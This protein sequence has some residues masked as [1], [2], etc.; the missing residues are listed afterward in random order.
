MIGK[1]VSHY[2]ITRELGAGGM[3]VVY[4]A[5]DTK[6]DRTVALKFLPPESTRDPDAKARFVHEAKAASAIDHPNVCNIYEIDETD[7]GQLFLA[8][9]C[10]EGE[11][12]KKRIE[13]GPLPLDDALDITRQVAE[14]LAKAHE[15]DI[16]HRDIKPANIFITEDGVVKIL[17]FGLAK[18]AGQAL[19]TKTGT[20][21]GTAGYMSPEQGRGEATDHRTDL[22]CLGVVLYE[23][24]TG[25]RPFLGDHEQALIYSILNQD[26]EPVTGLRTGVSMELER[27]ID[28]CLE[29]E[30]AARY[31]TAGD[32]ASDLSRHQ[33]G[34]DSAILTTKTMPLKIQ[35][36][37]R[38]PLVVG[39]GVLT[40]VLVLGALLFALNVGNLRDRWHGEENLSPIRSL[41]VLPFHNLMGDAE[42][43]FFVEGMH[44]SLITE[45]S[46]IGTLRVISRTSAMYFRETDKSMPEIAHELDVDALVE[47][48]VLR[49][50]NRVR[51][52]AQLIRGSND[53][54]LWA[55]DYDRDL[56]DILNLLSEVAR[57]I[58]GEID[59]ALTPGQQERLTTER[60]VDPDVYEMFLR[61][62]H[63][64]HKFTE[65]DVLISRDYFQQ[66]I[67]ADPNFALAHAGLSGSLI[68]SSIV[69]SVPSREV[70]PL[71]KE[72]A[73][74]AMA[75]DPGLS[76]AHTVLGFV[77][78][79]S[80]WDWAAG[81]REFRRALELNPNDGDA[82]HGLSNILMIHGRFDEAV[83]LV[84]RA[85]KFDPYSYLRNLPVWANLM[86][87]RRY[88]LAITE[89]ERWR[90]FSGQAGAGWWW[91]FNIYFDQGRYEEAMVELRHSSTGCDPESGPA[92]E[93]AYAESGIQGAILVCTERLTALSL[94]EHIDPISVSQYFALAGD[95]EKTF[96]WLEK[97]YEE[98]APAIHLLAQPALDPYRS[99][100][101]FRDLMRR[102][103]IR[104]S[105]WEKLGSGGD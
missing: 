94:S 25:R 95:T 56:K 19:L 103:D 60:T 62:L 89:V 70:L 37:S 79:Y 96:V 59:I 75:L 88:Q 44:E 92:M 86:I 77:E 18:L 10:Y 83:E 90:T 2:R 30:P 32:L 47:G 105:A 71:A 9:A 104:E 39:G 87:A 57:S 27:L 5:V 52:T 17:D 36:R 26:P 31:Q 93:K 67:D 11:T 65:R 97:V 28:R 58:A 14:G 4:E 78:M 50:G 100:P 13:R 64:L 55:E 21:L 66:A 29:K 35:P 82:L 6:L 74:R 24:V 61:G 41:A 72:A 84:T 15:R 102:M 53:E 85:R 40:A 12:L 98:R 38:H 101:R 42:Q 33:R 34:L 76:G 1:T 99:D 54:H 48:S 80:G 46:K 20:T 91:L 68:V 69:S 49:V 23:M 73:L 51:I 8:M 22:W 3:G 45:L 63:F 43:D 16:V 81:E 7:D